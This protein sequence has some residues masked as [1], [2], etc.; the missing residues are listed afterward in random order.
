MRQD[1][2]ADM[3]SVVKN[4]EKIGKTECIAPV[5]SLAREVLKIMQK[6]DYIG[7]FEFIDDGRAGK[8]KIELKNR[9]NGC[10]VIKPRYPVKAGVFEKFEKRFLPARGFGVLILSTTSGIM[11]H[12]E[13]KEK[14]IGGRLIGYIY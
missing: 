3:F 10:G 5:S 12:E 9:I 7:V 11:T 4:A 6:H 14:K 2:L 1:T 8:F 13:A